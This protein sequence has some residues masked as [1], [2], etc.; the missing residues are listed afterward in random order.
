MT[1]SEVKIFLGIL[2]EMIGNLKGTFLGDW[3]I[4]LLQQN[5]RQKALLSLLLLINLLTMVE[6]PVRVT[7]NSNSLIDVIIRNK[8][9][10]HTTTRVVEVGYSDHIA[11]I[12]NIAVKCLFIHSGKTVREAFSKRNNKY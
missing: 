10:Y 1:H 9:F 3:N 11:Q 5:I 6:C 2:D 4:N 12:M 7:T 8:I